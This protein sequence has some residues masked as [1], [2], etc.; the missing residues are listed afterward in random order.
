M[1]N[2]WYNIARRGSRDETVKEHFRDNCDPMAESYAIG[3]STI[4]DEDLKLL[5]LVRLQDD[6]CNSAQALEV[7]YGPGQ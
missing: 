4:L 3:L 1:L 5:S 2:E 7:N 6:G